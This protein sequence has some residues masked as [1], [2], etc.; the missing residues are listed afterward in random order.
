MSWQTYLL[1]FIEQQSLWDLSISAFRTDPYFVNNPPH[2]GLGKTIKLYACTS[3]PVAHSPQ[4]AQGSLLVALTSY[5]GNAGLNYQSKDGML[6]TD[7][8]VGL[9]SVS[10]GTSNTIM[11]GERPPPPDFRFGW[12]YAG[13]GQN[14][15]GSCDMFLGASELNALHG[16]PDEVDYKA[17]ASG[18]YSFAAGT[19][20]NS[21][22]AFHFWSYHSG[23]A[24]FLFGDGS[25][26]FLAY[27]ATS[28]L[29]DLAT[30]AGG[31]VSIVTN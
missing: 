15:G 4:K 13:A 5:L 3:D 2:V 18:P 17:C 26:R 21:C 9:H 6:F 11:V 8:L 20:S 31:E 1:P 23:G 14:G 7:S 25:T 28:V 22:D 29:P 24:N 10:D 16:L 30:R 12:W 19:S 27:T